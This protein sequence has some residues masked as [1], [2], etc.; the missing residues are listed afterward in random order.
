MKDITLVSLTLV[1]FAL[2]ATSHVGIVLGLAR[3]TPRLRAIV[4]LLVAPLAPYWAS[5]ERMRLRAAGWVLGASLYA[6][7]MLA[8]LV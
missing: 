8:Q 7:G 6:A 2:L 3:R 5:R 4:A 1:G